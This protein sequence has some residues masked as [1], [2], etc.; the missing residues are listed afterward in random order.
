MARWLLGLTLALVGC[1]NGAPPTQPR[2]SPSAVPSANVPFTVVRELADVDPYPGGGMKNLGPAFIMH[3][4]IRLPGAAE[5]SR[6]VIAITKVPRDRFQTEAVPTIAKELTLP[7]DTG[8][9]WSFTEGAIAAVVVSRPPLASF[10][11]IAT[12]EPQGSHYE[13]VAFVNGKMTRREGVHTMVRVT[14]ASTAK[15]RMAKDARGRP[16]AVAFGGWLAGRGEASA[17]PTLDFRFSW[18]DDDAAE[19]AAREFIAAVTRRRSGR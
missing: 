3:A 19:K 13:D 15:A 4:P 2:T 9:I 12:A 18:L 7:P 11:D 17:E 10:D 5:M 8:V 6:Q 14:F 16:L 1:G